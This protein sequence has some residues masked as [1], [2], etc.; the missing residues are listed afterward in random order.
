M[1]FNNLKHISAKARGGNLDFQGE[2]SG[3]TEANSKFHDYLAV[4]NIV[5]H[6]AVTNGATLLN[7]LLELLHRHFPEFDRDVAAREVMAREEI[8]P[9]VI[10]PGLAVPHARLSG[11]EQPLIALGCVPGGVSCGSGGDEGKVM[12]PLLTPQEDPI[13]QQL[14]AALAEDFASRRD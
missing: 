2:R 14:L 5:C 10:A 11:L 1:I 9:T 6:P 8:F 13:A 4:D 3:M 12:I 7:L